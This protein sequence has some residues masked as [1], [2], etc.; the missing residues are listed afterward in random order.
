[1]RKLNRIFE[2]QHDE[3][4]CG[5]SC[6]L[7]IVNF[8]GGVSTREYLR[9]YSG[10]SIDGT[11]L[12][13][14][15]QAADSIGLFSEAF[16]ADL[17]S[18]KQLKSPTI[19]HV[20]KNS[21]YD[22]YIV[23]FCWNGSHFII[24][25]PEIGI[26]SITDKDLLEIWK[27]KILLT[28]EVT[29]KFQKEKES[30]FKK[31]DFIQKFFLNNQNLI[32]ATLTL[33]FFI[34][35]FGLSTAIFIEK[36]IDVLIPSGDNTIVLLALLTWGALL[37][38]RSVFIFIRERF[39]INLSLN[40]QYF[41]IKDYL[42]K[43][44]NLPK[45]FFD[46]RKTGD[47]ST[48]LN[49]IERIQ[50][51][52]MRLVGE[53]IIEVLT[54]VC[55]I[56]FIFFYHSQVGFFLITL[57]PVYFIF[58]Y[59]V[60]QRIYNYNNLVMQS[61]ANAES[62]YLDSVTGI[63][64]IKN[65]NKQSIFLKRIFDRFGMYL[66][67][68]KKLN[69]FIANYKISQDLLGILALVY[70]VLFSV[71]LVF[72]GNLQVGDLIAI[73]TIVSISFAS[74]TKLAVSISNF[75]ESRVA[76]ERAYEV[77]SLDDE[78]EIQAIDKKNDYKLNSINIVNLSFGF[79][80]RENLFE[81]VSLKIE[82]GSST[83]LFGSIGSGKSTLLQI[84][85]KFYS[86][87]SGWIYVND[88]QLKNLNTGLWRSLIGVVPQE[89]K[90]F[91][92]S[93]LFN[94]CFDS[95]FDPE[96]VI[97]FCRSYGFDKYFNCLPQEYETILGETGVRLSGGQKQILAISRALFCKPKFLFLDEPTASLDNK[98]ESFI[99]NLLGELKDE[100]GIFVI[101]HKRELKKF[102]DEVIYFD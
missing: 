11:T 7:M 13:G 55:A 19:L 4:D 53:D 47:L 28:F 95:E 38:S 18:L 51:S 83:F 92:D 59:L 57:I 65:A 80:G 74:V 56:S 91:N 8:F 22:H 90:I 71:S 37:I 21:Q 79:P 2:A 33:G 58:I 29:E 31:I 42:R 64:T 70:I 48:R 43:I 50:S 98:T 100:I 68:S 15:I 93:V 66:S 82:K 26:V 49:D 20:Q 60:Q 12:L 23:C 54:L 46:T 73:I 84:L 97:E 86:P 69:L 96:E 88:Y 63:S 36:L 89:V 39:L 1:M 44:L 16:E 40:I 61:Y 101:T 87:N 52:L 35:F 30:N 14:L 76:F 94:I 25:D 77:I 10:T 17:N 32:I 6:L 3:S 62:D 78:F 75:Q 102:A 9:Q 81:G 45:T 5:V 85:Q 24:G 72:S 41:L 99:L 67:N 34:S 27:S